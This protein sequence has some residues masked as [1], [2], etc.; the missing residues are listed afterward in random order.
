[1]VWCIDIVNCILDNKSGIQHIIGTYQSVYDLA[2]ETNKN[3]QKI[4]VPSELKNI[5]PL[6][7]NLKE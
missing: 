2:K 6:T 1:M 3:I 4:P 7:L 5:L